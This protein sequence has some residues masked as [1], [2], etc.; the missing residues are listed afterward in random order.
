MLAPQPVQSPIQPSP[1][2]SRRTLWTVLGIVGGSIVLATLLFS[3][4]IAAGVFVGLNAFFHTTTAPVPV[5]AHYYLSIMEQ[6][7][8]QAYTDLDQHAQI[9][10]QSLDQH[11][12]T[13]L[14]TTTDAQEGKVSGYSIDPTLQGNDSARVTITVHRGA[15]IYEVHLQLQQKGTVWK[16]LSADGI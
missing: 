7:Y 9:N 1:G 2:R 5:A 15:H 3:L 14:A 6:N 11:A 16:I 4:L 8:P 12:F 10:G 13:T